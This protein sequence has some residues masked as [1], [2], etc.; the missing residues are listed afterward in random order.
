MTKEAGID[1]LAYFMIG[2]PT[3]TRDEILNTIK[4]AK[5]LKPD[6]C[7]FSITT[8]FPATPLY[9]MGLEQGIFKKDYWKEF[10]SNPTKDFAPELWEE[11]LNREELVELLEY[12]YKSFYTRPGYVFKKVLKVRSFDEFKRKAKAGL[13]LLK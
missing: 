7:H 4:Y 3:E 8:P 6:Y 13:R 11:N 2:S 5:K 12:A 10:A 9:A 1:I